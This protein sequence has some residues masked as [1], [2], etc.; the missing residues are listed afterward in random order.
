MI[1]FLSTCNSCNPLAV[2]R[3]CRQR[4]IRNCSCREACQVRTSLTR[5]E[6]SFFRD[7]NTEVPSPRGDD[8]R[9][10]V[11][12]CGHMTGSTSGNDRE[13]YLSSLHVWLKV[14][15]CVCLASTRGIRSFQRGQ[16]PRKRRVELN[17]VNKIGN[18][19]CEREA[20][21]GLCNIQVS[22]ACPMRNLCEHAQTCRVSFHVGWDV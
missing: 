22:C 4:R 5:T 2:S 9:V 17:V 18:T 20:P 10:A 21:Y 15:R 16:R 14:L 13:A 6:V 1:E 11:G 12:S 7:P 8:A 3:G 19:V